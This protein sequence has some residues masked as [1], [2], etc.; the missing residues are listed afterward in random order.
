MKPQLIQALSKE[1]YVKMM[2]KLN[3]NDTNVEQKNVAHICIV[4]TPLP[5]GFTFYTSQYFQSDHPNVLRLWFDDIDQD[6][7]VPIIGM[8][9]YTCRAITLDQCRVIK[10]FILQHKNANGFLIHC[11]LGVSRSG[12]VATYAN[13]I[14][15]GEKE[16]FKKNNPDIDPRQ[17]ILDKLRSV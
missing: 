2:Q 3:I 10:D 15:D 4:D 8:G 16:F 1:N 5:S 11:I 7:T 9:Q 12:A 14:L 6:T 17:S 13:E